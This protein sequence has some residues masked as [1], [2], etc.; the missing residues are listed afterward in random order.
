VALARARLVEP[1]DV[2]AVED[3][4]TAAVAEVRGL[5]GGAQYGVRPL[6]GPGDP[7]RPMWVGE[8]AGAVVGYLAAARDGATGTIDAIFVDPGCRAVGV[9]G[10]MLDAALAWMVG[11]GCTGV[12]AYAL[13]GARHTK[14]FFEEAGLTARLLVVHRRL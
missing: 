14:N 1:P 8:L 9:G 4:R 3:L 12:D 7:A 10:A 11:A 5:R 2:A 6:P 13:P